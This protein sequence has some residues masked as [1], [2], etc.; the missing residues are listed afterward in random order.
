MKLSTIFILNALFALLGGVGLLLIPNQ[1]MV[2]YGAPL[3]K[4]GVFMAQILG[5]VLL[6][7]AAISWNSRNL[8]DREALN[9]ILL[10]FIIAHVGSGLLGL[11][12]GFTGRLGS[13]IWGDVAAHGLLGFAFAYYRFGKS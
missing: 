5:T 11:H 3:D 12:A 10:G 7:I 4:G 6:G 9:V 13:M 1:L 2:P 8:K